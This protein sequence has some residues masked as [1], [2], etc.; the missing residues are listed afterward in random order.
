MKIGN[1]REATIILFSY[2]QEE[3]PENSINVHYHRHYFV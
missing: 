3:E 1:A 2:N